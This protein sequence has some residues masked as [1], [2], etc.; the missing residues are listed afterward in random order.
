MIELMARRQSAQPHEAA[1]NLGGE[2]VREAS[3]RL[4]ERQREAL[5]LCAFEQRSYEEI[6]TIMETSRDSVPQLI[7]RARI[8]LYD[9]LRGTV[10]ASPTK[11][12]ALREQSDRLARQ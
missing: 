4:P 12:N 3:L 11:S 6:A 2:G 10:L 8:N 7:S 1:P 9:E 5:E